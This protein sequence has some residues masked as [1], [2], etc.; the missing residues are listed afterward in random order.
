MSGSKCFAF[1]AL[2]CGLLSIASEC[3]AQ[4]FPSRPI[5]FVVPYGAGGAPDVM[6]R[7]IGQRLGENVGQPGVVDNRPGANGIIAAEIVMK[8][9]ADGYTLFIADTGHVAINPSLYPT[10]PYDPLRDFAPVIHAISTPIFLAANAALPIRS[11]REL[12]DYAKAHPGLNYGS[13]GSGTPH[14]LGMEQFKLL[15]QVNMTN[16]PYKGVAQSV[17]ALMVGDVAVTFAALPSLAPHVKAG[18]VRL[19]AVGSANRTPLMPDLP[20][21]AEAGLP[22]F[23]IKAEVG[24]LAP[25]GTPRDVIAKLNS[26]IAKVLAAP[27]VVQRLSALGIDTIGGTP[28]QYAES[29]RAD[30]QSYAKLVKDARLRVD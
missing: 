9:P 4:D 28:Q 10:L 17:P 7:V 2:V 11:V 29:I 21:I 24:F 16:I 25:A 22:G 19:I 30:M 6:A 8:A 3:A 1:A 12:I 26:E 23:V 20:T 18:K 14:H 15:A 13:P 5:R 27:D